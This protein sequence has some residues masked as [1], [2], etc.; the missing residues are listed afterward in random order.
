MIKF[1][2]AENRGIVFIGPEGSGKT[3]MAKHLSADLDMPY[4]T[5]G[6]AIRQLATYDPGRLGNAC[7]QMFE[8]HTYLE[9]SL[10]L[11]IL[12]DRLSQADTENGFVL[13]GGL[14][15]VE[16]T[17]NFPDMLAKADRNLPLSVFHLRIPGWMSF[18]RLVSGPQARKR[19]DDTIEGVTKRLSMFYHQLDER[20]RLVRQQPNW[21]LIFVDATQSPQCVYENIR[22]KIS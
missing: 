15:T 7:R 3:T 12:E 14:R 8:E 11:E 21:E 2:M 17:G 10:L 1:L 22:E 9:G 20:V 5:T 16:E 19:S 13:D 4:I 6:D 18:D